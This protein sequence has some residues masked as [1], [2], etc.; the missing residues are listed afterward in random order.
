LEISG[1]PGAT[2][3]LHEPAKPDFCIVAEQ[4]LIDPSQLGSCRQD[5]ALTILI[6]NR[7]AASY[8]RECLASIRDTIGAVTVEVLLVDGSSTDDSVSVAT[9]L[10]PDVRVITVPESLG[11]VRGNNVG[12]KEARGR[13]TM[14]LN[15]D[16]V[17]YPG[18]LEELVRFMDEHPTVG[19]ASGSIL[20]PDG[21]DQGVVRR[22]P[23]IMNGLFGRRS[24]LSRWFPNNPWY[25]RYMQ[26][27]NE[28]GATPYETEI[29]SACSM[30]FRTDLV[31]N[32]GGMDERFQ[33]Y[34]V[35]AELCGRIAR[36]DY[37][38]VCVPQARIMHHEGKGGS[39]STFT[40]RF[41]MNIAFNHGAYLAYVEY[42]QLGQFDPRRLVAML[43]LT[44]RA[45]LL[46]VALVLRPSRATSSGG[47]N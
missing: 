19:A 10:W 2:L 36:K 20:N 31:R 7:N 42:H 9:E 23:S 6:V 15:S 12:L 8:L 14:Y 30:I 46:S 13:Y 24:F 45:F 37:Q 40:K 5:P 32:L 34:W 33:F 38:I 22:F 3:D 4:R 27:R 28:E 47:K 26:S 1:N 39:T 41:K 43:T 11:Y 17:V 44:A 16:T 21:T 35:D 29:L 18:A 25:R